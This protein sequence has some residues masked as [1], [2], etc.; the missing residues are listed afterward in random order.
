VP[1]GCPRRR[2]LHHAPSTPEFVGA[3]LASQ[4]AP[5]RST[6]ST[7]VFFREQRRQ[8]RTVEGSSAG[9][10]SVRSAPRRCPPTRRIAPRAPCAQ[11]AGASSCLPLAGDA[12]STRDGSVGPADE[13]STIRHSCRSLSQLSTEP[14]REIK[15]RHHRVAG[16][17]AAVADPEVPSDPGADDDFVGV[18]AAMGVAGGAGRFEPGAG[19]ET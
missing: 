9:P 5:R 7:G 6:R 19:V 17:A 8:E 14:T 3:R 1:G 11:H 15:V 10:I 2:H 16:E 12:P 18:S 13:P 4:W